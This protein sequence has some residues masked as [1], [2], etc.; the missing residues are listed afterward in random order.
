MAAGSVGH[1]SGRCEGSQGVSLHWTKWAAP[2]AVRGV[3]FHH[4]WTGNQV[5]FAETA[6]RLAATGRYQAVVFSA[7]GT[8]A[9]SHP[10]DEDAYGVDHYVSD[11]ISVANFHWGSS[12]KFT[13]VGHSMGGLLGMELGLTHGDRLDQ[14][15]LVAPAPSSGLRFPAEYFEPSFERWLRARAGDTQ[16]V[17]QLVAEHLAVLPVQPAATVADIEQVVRFWV[18]VGLQASPSHYRGSWRMMTAYQRYHRLK[19]LAVPT[20]MIC[21]SADNLLSFNLK[22]YKEMRRVATLHIFSNCGHSPQ[23]ELP[24][25]F[26]RVLLQFLDYGPSNWHAMVAKLRAKL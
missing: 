25:E 3:L 10:E 2:G 8:G 23:R 26:L 15:I 6:E 21:G 7:R 22:D 14:L 17:D 5:S 24:D 20:L 12:Q 18:N 4:G 11:I 16:A 19:E 9:T 1:F 13:Y